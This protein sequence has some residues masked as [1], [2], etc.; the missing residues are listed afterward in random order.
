MNKIF[1]K[2]LSL[3]IFTTAVLF[4]VHDANTKV[5][6]DAVATKAQSSTSVNGKAQNSKNQ[7][8]CDKDSSSSYRCNDGKMHIIS[9]KTYQLT[10]N[11]DQAVAIEASK[12]DTWIVAENVT[13]TGESDKSERKVWEIGAKV[14]EEGSIE[15]SN[16][17]VKDVLTGVSAT[18]GEIQMKGGSIDA[19]KVG[20]SVT[21]STDSSKKSGAHLTNT[22]IKTSDKAIGLFSS[23]STGSKW[24]QGEIYMQEGTID[25]TN[26]TGVKVEGAGSVI[27]NSVSITGRGSQVSSTENFSESSAF[28]ILKSDGYIDFGRGEIDVLDAHGILLQGED[29][30]IYISESTVV[31]KGSDAFYGMRF[32]QDPQAENNKRNHNPNVVV[33]EKTSFTV[34]QSTAIYNSKVYSSV[35]LSKEAVLSGDLLLRADDSSYLLVK[36]CASSTLVG[37]ARTDENSDAELWLWEGAKWILTRPKN[38]NLLDSS[39]IGDSSISLIDFIDSFIIF[40]QPSSSEAGNYQTLRIGKGTGKVYNAQG[41]AHLYLNTYLDKGG[42]IKDQKTD[43]VLI[44]GDVEGKTIVHV[45]SVLGS[46]G[47]Y[48]GSGGN[49]QGISIIQVS[50]KAEKDSFQ[51]DGDYV[52]LNDLPYQYKLY[53]YGP[54][55]DLGEADSSQ[56]LVEGKEKFWDFRLQNRYVAPPPEPKSGPAPQPKSGPAPQPSPKPIPESGVRAVVPQVPTYL[57]LSNSLFHAGLM[58]ISNQNKQLETLRTASN[59]MLRMRKNPVSFLRGYGGNYRYISDLSAL[60]YGYG[61]DLSYNGVEAGVLLQTIENADNSI[62]FG[63]MTSYGK[64]FLQPLDVEQSQK[65]AFDKWTATAYGSMQHDAGFYVDGLLSYGHFKGDVVTLARGTTATLK[66]NPLSVSLTGGQTLAMGYEGFV[67]DP[68]VQI[69]Y[70]H[71]QFSKVRDIDNFNIEMGKL[72]QWVARVG[73]RLSKTLTVPE[74][75]SVFSLYGKLHLAHGFEEKKSVHFKDA[76][77]LGAFG[78]SLEAGLGLNAQLSEKFV[79][80]ADL[81]YQHN[82]TKAGFSGISFSGGLRYRF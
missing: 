52:A 34:P 49:S 82:L 67:F 6:A 64:L 72:D 28:H 65:S 62:S 60:E 68:Q 24:T 71:L 8:S 56:R 39:S 66:G 13:I 7:F 15:L 32:L 59:G 20:V 27:L 36:A 76:F 55:S 74:K 78:S 11:G 79:L 17:T 3:C 69:V 25:F 4:F 77:Q 23:N 42:D 26:G 80:H 63:V 43:R 61:G 37:G 21:N 10:N 5:Q 75:D 12:K 2:H 9:Q 73:G 47:G 1:Q 58:D 30:D 46:P 48:T 22:N 14:S 45:Q 35:R 18:Q 50:G 33:L 41:N 31:V 44:Y 29:A 38:G 19:S 51:L 70:Q 53:A 81:T 54:E 57:L 16:S 40:E